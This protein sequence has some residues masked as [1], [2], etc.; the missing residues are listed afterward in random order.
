MATSGY[1][2]EHDVTV[3][4][5]AKLLIRMII[6]GRVRNFITYRNVYQRPTGTYYVDVYKKRVNVNKF[7][8][9]DA[10]FILIT[11]GDSVIQEKLAHVQ[12]F[13]EIQ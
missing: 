7:N 12:I 4:E 8:S 10:D 2:S 9:P 3:F 5:K 1:T 6:D 11:N 13:E